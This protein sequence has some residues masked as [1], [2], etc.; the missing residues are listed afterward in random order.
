[1]NQKTTFLRIAFFVFSILLFN[2]DS[3][4]QVTTA[5]ITGVVID[6]KGEGLPGATVIAVHVPSGSKYASVSN[7]SGR[8][9][10]P[11]VRVGGPYKLTV[12]FIGYKDDVREGIITS[13]G[14]SSNVDF[15]MS[16]EGTSLDEVTI[17]GTRSDV[18]NSDRT[19]AS[20][21][22]KREQFEK[23]PT[24]S[25]SLTDFST[26][27]PQAGP[28]FS[29]GGRSALYN[30]FSIDGATSNNVFGLSPLPGGQSSSQPISVDA[31][32][33]LSVSLAPYDVSQGSFTGAGVNAITRSGTNEVQG[34]VYYFNRNVNLVNKKVGDISSPLTTFA[35]NSFGFRVGGPIIKNKL[36]IFINAEKE[37]RNDPAV[38]FAAD[39]VGSD[40]KPFQQTSAELKKL[41]DFL[42]GT[43][44][45]KE[46]SFDPGTYENFDLLTSST[47]FLT[48]LDWNI[49][50]N[51]KFT[52]RYNQMDSF[53]DVPPSGSGGPFSSPPGGRSNS[54]NAVPFSNTYYRINNNLKNVIG[55]L[56]SSFG[57]SKFSNNLQVGYSAFRDYRQA[58]GGAATPEFP[59][60]D[61]VGPN[62]STLTSFGAEPFTPNNRLDQDII[63]LND[64]FDMFLGKHTVS[65]GTANEFYTFYN[66]FTQLVKGVYQYASINDFIGAAS[67][68]ASATT[69]PAPQQFGVQY[70][71]IP[72]STGAARWKTSQ[73]GFYA[74]DKFNVTKN[75]NLTYGVRV[76]IPTFND[77]GLLQNVV[78]DSMTFADG[79]KV[80]VGIL[81]KS[82]PLWSPRIGFNLDVLGNKKL[83]VRGGTGVFTGRIPF[84][85]VSNQISN[86]GLFFGVVQPTGAQLTATR[87]SEKPYAPVLAPFQGRPLSQT[88]T[89]NSTVPNFKF[90]QVWRSNIAADYQLG[91]DYVVTGEFIYTKDLNAVYI[92]D[93]NLANTVGTVAGD[94]RPLF[95]AASGDA[96]V[97][98]GNDRRVND[99]IVQALVLDNI[100]KGYSTSATIQFQKIKGAVQG[101]IAYTF[102]DSKD[103]NGQSGSTAGS[104]FTGNGVVNT[105]NLPNMSYAN[106]LSPHRIVGFI[107]YNKVLI[108]NLLGVSGSLV[109]QGFNNFNFSYVYGGSPN[110]DGINN[111][112]LLYIPRNQSEILLTTTDARDT[113]TPD[114]IWN[115]LNAYI[116]QDKYLNSRRGQYAERN[117]AFAP[118][119]NRLNSRVLI[120]LFT[121]VAGK[122]N[123]LQLSW[124]TFNLLNLISSNAGLA[125]STNRTALLNFSGYETPH[126]AATP[127]TGRPI[128]TFATNSDNTPL[129]KSYINDQGLSSRWQM[130]L[131]IRYIFN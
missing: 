60:V 71:A 61:I 14:T 44:N 62:G 2:L 76:D 26:L 112:D 130:Q 23:L 12:T 21:N 98:P 95:G 15:K 29:F 28:G 77:S 24:L 85:W 118:W 122:K 128:Y 37:S 100:N 92:R 104:L 123:T 105:P 68:P 13:L 56:N 120:D 96:A 119:V 48:R 78:S 131:G 99:R 11:A 103:V 121:N 79:E 10:L 35:N 5:S 87:F 25:R 125:Q 31:I 20:T 69:F 16:T 22:I 84:V 39:G 38:L 30:N 55:E 19:G 3:K 9:T 34:S 6:D 64:K 106:N 94:G 107:S 57:Q 63:Q 58:A 113:R 32:Q 4:A 49:N 17:S 75:L 7:T 97:A 43:G 27:T 102:T 82:T 110:S 90:P 83:Q 46:W 42:I 116:S 81:P 72:N 86:N 117:G 8:Y 127:T 111:N 53:R 108:K 67:A 45:G 74:Q 54:N 124:E 129:A 126:T 1:M 65:V 50:N 59:L 109:Y 114:E 66:I 51:H 73:Y 41:K 33:E 52:V 47:K 115:Q 93:A 36:F 89:I 91:T 70:I 18:I 101:S 80:R 40:G 88:F